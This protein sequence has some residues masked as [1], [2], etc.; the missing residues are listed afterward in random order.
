MPFDLLIKG[1]HVLDPGQ[2]LDAALDIGIEGST[3]TALAADLPAADARRVIDAGGSGRHVVPGLIDIH[4]H[5][6]HGATT[7][8]VGMECCE[9]DSIGVQ[10]G[11]TTVVDGGS[12]GVANIGVFPVHI[13]PR[14]AT[15]TICFANAAAHAHTMPGLSDMRTVDELD[16]DAMR[17]C[18]EHN[19]GLVQGVK[20][21]LVGPIVAEQ[22]Q[23]LVRR[24]TAMAVEHDVP[25]M[26]HIGDFGRDDAAHRVRMAELTAF[27]LEQLRAGDIITHLC[28]P[29]PGGVLDGNGLALPAL[30]KAREAGIVL[31][32]ALGRGNFGYAVAAELAEQGIH[33]DTISS[34]LTVY[35]AD[36]HS[37]VEC[38]AKFMAIGYSLPDVVRMTTANAAAAIGRAGDLGALAVG[39]EA[40]ITILDVVEGDFTFLDTTDTT[41]TGRHGIAPVH[42][43]RAGQLYAPRWGTHPWGW[44]PATSQR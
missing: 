7:P 10:S 38:M 44:L 14:A 36:F 41:F 1:G 12:V 5:V 42:T 34:D 4:T 28:T 40:D 25:L 27:L 6:A 37:L 15:R 22:G 35:G 32:S 17:L 18:V 13:Q 23:E 30:R 3:I 26:I 16:L 39:R 21:R 31:D 24:A 43:V 9:P 19:P 29:N 33:P 8:G 11:V 2:G 20:L